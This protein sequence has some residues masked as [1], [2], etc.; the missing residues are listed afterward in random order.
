MRQS[1]KIFSGMSSLKVFTSTG[2]PKIYSGLVPATFGSLVSSSIYFGSYET[3]KRLLFSTS[4]VTSLLPR[5]TIHM[6]AAASGNLASSFVFVPKDVLKQQ[7]QAMRTGALTT[8]SPFSSVTTSLPQVV[9]HILKTKGLKGFYPSYRVTLLRNIPSAVVRF[10]VYEELRIAVSSALLR[11]GTAGMGRTQVLRAEALGYLLAGGIASALS[12]ALTTPLDVV[13]TRLA[14]GLIAPGTPIY[15]CLRTIVAS[16]GIKGL[17]VGVQERVLWSGLFGG[18]GLSAYECFKKL[19][20]GPTEDV[21]RV[22]Y[23]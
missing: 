16:D 10:T 12:S 2:I 1:N 14:T 17:F 15:I 19:L 22:E 13:K 9:K 20:D 23:K 21:K 18:M 7:M 6:L 3:A 11:L 5:P 8:A 4:W